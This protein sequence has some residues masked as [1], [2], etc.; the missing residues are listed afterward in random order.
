MRRRRI[1]QQARLSPL[2]WPAVLLAL[3]ACGAPPAG[4]QSFGGRTMGSTYEVK[5]VGDVPLAEVCAIVDEEL[6][7]FD[8]AFSNWRPD[9]EIARL[10]AHA[11]TGPFPVSVRFAAVLQQAL[12]LAEATEGAFDPTVKPLSDLYRAVRQD[13]AR[14]PDAAA[15]AAARDRVGW[16]RVA[17]RDGSVHKARA[18][19]QLDLDG[20]VAGAAA[21]AIAARLE[22]CNL[23]G[24]YLEITG[25]VLC[26][27]DKGEGLPWRIGVVD[28]ESDA[29]GA[30]LPVRTVAL[31]DRALCTSGDYRNWQAGDAALRHHVF[32]PRTGRSA[33]SG[34]A[35]ASLLA[36]SAAAADALA[37]AMLVLGD[38]HTRRLWPQWQRFGVH[39]ALLLLH[40][41]DGHLRAAEITWPREQ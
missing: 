27:G 32:D 19:V 38:G 14:H 10:N 23:R 3:A 33:G 8:A 29:A 30:D 39:G 4:V 28:P 13:P 35:S 36:D 7:A 34:V 6:A 41:D 11:S 24:L 1:L 40:G 16:R 15:L 37:T 21:D 17:L 12:E 26:R 9:S 2:P 20:I 25:E 18:D 5:F 22:P 31:R